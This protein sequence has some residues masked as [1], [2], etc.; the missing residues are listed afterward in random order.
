MFD[1]AKC[2]LPLSA[3]CDGFRKTL[4]ENGVFLRRNRATLFVLLSSR[5][6]AIAFSPKLPRRHLLFATTLSFTMYSNVRLLLM[7]REFYLKV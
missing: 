5:R 1:T 2:R 6:S 3:V 7:A 4:R